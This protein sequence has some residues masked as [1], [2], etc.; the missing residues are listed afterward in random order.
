MN[1]AQFDAVLKDIEAHGNVSQALRERSVPRTAF[2]AKIAAEP[3]AENRYA[4]AKRLGIVAFADEIVDI[5]DAREGDVIIDEESGRRIIDNEAVQR[6]RLRVDTRKWLLAKI[7]PKV[8][9]EKMLL[10]SDPENPIP[11]M[12]V[13]GPPKAPGDGGESSG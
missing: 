3:E 13:V 4:R 8:Y 7:L 10:G 2:Y 1:D 11:P 12:V 6:A 5:A 9:G